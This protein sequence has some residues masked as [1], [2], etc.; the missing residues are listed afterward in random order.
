MEEKKLLKN[1]TDLISWMVN[2]TKVSINQ[3]DIT[4]NYDED[5]Q[6]LMLGI[7]NQALIS[8][9]L[10]LFT[11]TIDNSKVITDH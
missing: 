8:N 4:L 1:L 2:W 5:Q 3:V 10:K 7:N 6:L 9:E 11:L